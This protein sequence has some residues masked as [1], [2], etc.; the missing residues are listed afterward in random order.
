MTE[1]QM[2]DK[3][4]FHYG[5]IHQLKKAVEEMKELI[6]E[7][8]KNNFIAFN[9]KDIKQEYA[10]VENCLGYIR[11][12]FKFGETSIK[13]IREE[14]LKREIRRIQDVDMSIV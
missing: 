2:R 8:E 3:I 4:R 1:K 12:Y 13:P 9:I 11:D 7:L 5:S 14:K 10:D 6:H